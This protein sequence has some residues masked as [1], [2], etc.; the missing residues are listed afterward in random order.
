MPPS[1][2]T[3]GRTA[4][5]PVAQ[6]AGHPLPLDLQA[7]DEEE[8]RHQPV[9]DDSGRATRRSRSSRCR[10]SGG[11]GR[12]SRRT[13]STASSPTP[14]RRPWRCTS[15]MPPPASTARN[16]WSGRPNTGRA[17]DRSRSRSAADLARCR[18][19]AV[20]CGGLD[21][22][23]G[24]VNDDADQASRH[25][26]GRGYRSVEVPSS[27]TAGPARSGGRGA[28]GS[29][30]ITTVVPSSVFTNSSSSASILMSGMPSPPS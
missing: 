20:P 9:V 25:T 13:R 29:N 3:A 16:D 23:G 30:C 14:A 18:P 24:D 21:P 12:A 28:R 2:A 6:L 27:P 19:R 5:P 15:T 22:S 8:Q 10:R 7:D 17:G 26:R 1:A 4:A 11:C